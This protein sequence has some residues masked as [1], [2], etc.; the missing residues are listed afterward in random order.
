MVEKMPVT[1]IERCIT[2]IVDLDAVACYPESVGIVTVW[3]VV[4]EL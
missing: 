2:V 1:F 4:V 3:L